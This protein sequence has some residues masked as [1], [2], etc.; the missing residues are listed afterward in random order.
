VGP[1]EATGHTRTT[2]SHPRTIPWPAD[3][4]T[5]LARDGE[6]RP[7]AFVTSTTTTT[8]APGSPRC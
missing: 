4:K 8:T 5:G 2:K 7:L 6:R 1:K 3:H